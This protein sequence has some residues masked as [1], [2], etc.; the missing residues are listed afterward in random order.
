MGIDASAWV[1]TLNDA[2]NE[3]ASQAEQLQTKVGELTPAI[4]QLNKKFVT[5]RQ[6]TREW[7][8]LTRDIASV[9]TAAIKARTHAGKMKESWQHLLRDRASRTLTYN[10]EQFHIL[11]KIK[12]T[13]TIRVIVELLT[14]ECEPSV[15]SR[16]EALADWYKM[17]STI[18]LQTEILYKDLQVFQDDIAAYSMGLRHSQDRYLQLVREM[19]SRLREVGEEAPPPAPT[20]QPPC[21]TR[22]IR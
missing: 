16:T 7:Q 1:K 9:D 6:L 10:A 22:N 3:E 20:P 21:D 12:M 14:K 4:G 2:A 18:Y 15:T 11:E 13:E 17:A 8:D 5:D 19:T